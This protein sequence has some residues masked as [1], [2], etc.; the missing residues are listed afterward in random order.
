MPGLNI[1]NKTPS[2]GIAKGYAEAG[3][4]PP[5]KTF[6]GRRADEEVRGLPG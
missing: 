3:T 6:E 1:T 4:P 2:P 5:T